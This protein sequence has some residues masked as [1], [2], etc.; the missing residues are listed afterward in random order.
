ML[1]FLSQKIISVESSPYS[2]CRDWMALRVSI[3]L[4]L[5]HLSFVF[6]FL[7]LLFLSLKSMAMPVLMEK[8][9][10]FFGEGIFGIERKLV[11]VAV[12]L[13]LV[14]KVSDFLTSYRF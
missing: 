2:V 11:V 12:A 7:G 13:F 1:L 5:S 14:L 3:E 6:P 4:F 10:R 9:L 8:K